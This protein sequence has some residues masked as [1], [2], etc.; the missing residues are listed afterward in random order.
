[1]LPATDFVWN[2]ASNGNWNVGGNWNPTGPPTGTDNATIAVAGTYTV[3]LSDNL[4]ITNLTLNNATAT[5]NQTGGTLTVNGMITLTAGL[6]SLGNGVISGGSI[7]SGGGTLQGTTLGSRLNNVTVGI[8]VLDFGTAFRSILLQ[9][10]SN[11]GSG[12]TI[13]LSANST[14]LGFEQTVTHDNLVVNLTAANSVIEVNGNHTVT[15]GPNTTITNNTTSTNEIGSDNFVVGTSSVQN[16]GLIRN[17]GTGQLSITSD[18]FRNQSGG[19]VRS[20]AGTVA[21]TSPGEIN[22]TGGLFDV[23]GGTLT[24]GGANWDNNG[25]I[26]LSSGTLNLGGSF[27]TANIGSLTRTGGSIQ[28]TGNLNNTGDTLALTG[29]TGSYI[30]GTT[31]TAPVTTGTITGGS[32]TSSGGSTLRVGPSPNNRL[33]DVAVGV[34]VLDFSIGSG[35]V[36]LAGTT[37]LAAGTTIAL[38]GGTNVLGFDQ[39]TT[40][41]DLA[42]NFTASNGRVRIE[43]TRMVTFGANV[44]VTN[45][46]GGT[47][48]IDGGGTSGTLINQGLIRNVVGTI[49]NIGAAGFTFT[50]TGTLQATGG[51]LRVL[52]TAV[53]TNFVAGTLTGGTYLAQG[54]TLSFQTRQVSTIAAGTVVEIS[55][56][57]GA[58]DAMNTLAVNA[59]TFRV[60]GG[61]SFNPSATTTITNTGLI[62]I[63][64]T[65]TLTSDLI[66]NSG[67]TVRGAGT[68]A[69]NLTYNTTGGTLG[70]GQVPGNTGPA[71]LTVTGNLTLNANT[72]AAFKLNGSTTST[73]YDQLTVNGSVD[74]GNAVL[75]TT[76]GYIPATG[77]RLFLLN[78]TSAGA[79]TGTFTGL[80][81][82]STVTIG[83][84]TATIGYFGDFPT[85][86]VTGGNDVVLYNF[87]PVPEPAAILAVAAI[88][89]FAFP[90]IR[91]RS[92]SPPSEVCP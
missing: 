55:G 76:L 32:I 90:I 38:S 87:T 31:L 70:P 3:T 11:F 44:T 12:A 40:L 66:V 86:S 35:Q 81:N 15:F 68:L 60:T 29:A 27:T 47:A 88:A 69:G 45:S 61:Q 5:L 19:V 26:T 64:V 83:E 9:G 39:T 72:A 22:Q 85:N 1:L 8:G 43:N 54:T 57:A 71:V 16:Q 36:R 30:L 48:T 89:F 58:F 53:F 92:T 59:G 84:F 2:T 67:G 75:S 41:N 4:A 7:V 77:D 91:C 10:T 73:G 56:A 18:A 79:I 80:P 74:L 37:T 82:G 65:S 23:N 25:T 13:H 62:E 51:Q 46:S 50:N 34:N 20:T 17:I 49:T 24:L 63:G 52:D 6:Y 14:S 42:I 21:I 33:T 28:I 78:K